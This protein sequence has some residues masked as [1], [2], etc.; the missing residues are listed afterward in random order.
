MDFQDDAGSI[1]EPTYFLKLNWM[2]TSHYTQ[3]IMW[4]IEKKMIELH[5]NL[6]SNQVKIIKTLEKSR[7][8]R[9]MKRRN[10]IPLIKK[11]HY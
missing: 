7:K 1:G 4:K 8:C 9:M 2:A 10:E 11:S 3:K 5:D 6:S